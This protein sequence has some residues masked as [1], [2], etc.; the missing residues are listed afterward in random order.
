MARLRSLKKSNMAGVERVMYREP[1]VDF[2]CRLVRSQKNLFSI[3][4][5]VNLIPIMPDVFYSR[6]CC[7]HI[8][9]FKVTLATE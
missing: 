7:A 4:K 3:V 6:E 5:M 2:G 9:F 8:C 1:S